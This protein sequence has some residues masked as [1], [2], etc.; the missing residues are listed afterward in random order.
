MHRRRTRGTRRRWERA[1]QESGCNLTQEGFFCQAPAM[2]FIFHASPPATL[3]QVSHLT[4]F[5]SKPKG[6]MFFTLYTPP[7]EVLIN[8]P[9][10]PP[11]YP[12]L[13]ITEPNK[14]V[15]QEP[16]VTLP[17]RNCVRHPRHINVGIVHS[18]DLPILSIFL[19]TLIHMLIMYFK[20]PLET[21]Y[22]V[23][24]ANW[25][26]TIRVIWKLIITAITC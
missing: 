5:I 23:I 15:T 9:G 16:K 3:G 18:V 7:W 20:W 19:L 12:T 13:K 1:C 8:P 6:I 17:F 2:F 26:G 24:L 14:I 22:K 10:R 4:V 25:L 11:S 21:G